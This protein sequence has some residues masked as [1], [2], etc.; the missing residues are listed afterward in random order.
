ME[1][2]V[3]LVSYCIGDGCNNCLPYAN[4]NI[5]VNIACSLE[6]KKFITAVR[7]SISPFQLKQYEASFL[8][9]FSLEES[10][11]AP[12]SNNAAFCQKVNMFGRK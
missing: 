5:L 12:I 3:S 8:L 7:F 11:T 10:V 6:F 9:E 1:M 2:L 4:T